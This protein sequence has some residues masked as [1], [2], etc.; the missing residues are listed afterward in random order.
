MHLLR[1]DLTAEGLMFGDGGMLDVPDS[2]APGLAVREGMQ[3][4]L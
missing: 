2:A 3:A 4:H 1:E